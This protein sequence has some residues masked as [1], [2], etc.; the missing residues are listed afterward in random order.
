MELRCLTSPLPPLSTLRLRTHLNLFV[1]ALIGLM[2]VGCSK[3]AATPDV[4]A[5]LPLDPEAL[6]ARL[7]AAKPGDVISLP[8][9]TFTMRRGLNLS[10][11]G[12]TIRGAGKEATI[13][14][15]GTQSQGAEGLL[16]NASNFTIEGL[17][18]RNTRGDALK[19]NEG[20]N[21]V[22]RSVR[23]E[24]TGGP[25]PHNGA[26]GIYPVQCEGVLIEDSEAVGASD[27]GIY[28]GQSSRII[29]RNNRAEQ[30]VA[31]IEIENSTLADVHDNVVTNN[32]GGILVFDLP[33]IPVQGGHGTRVFKNRI[34]DNNTANFAPEGNIVGTVP[35]GT[36]VMINANDNIEVFDNDISGHQTA[37][38][39]II[40]YL[41]TKRPIN[42]PKY[43]PYPESIHVHHNRIGRGGWDPASDD[44]ARVRTK[45]S[46]GSLPAVLWDGIVNPA[47]L[48]NG[49]LP[50]AL[51]ICIHDNGTNTVAN[52]DA[53]NNFSNV[54]QDPSPFNCTLPALPPVK[55]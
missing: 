48:V 38:V 12:V 37:S 18:I 36:A 2:L 11:D 1:I 9:G 49:Q 26:Y 4:N 43:D 8:R 14:D 17:T 15:F 44:L 47:H 46:A 41:V 27:A 24:W 33:G 32:T 53:A 28:V 21:I 51:R 10:V 30:N 31:G 34:V 7:V 52:L 35:A 54:S 19:I 50:E 40:S 23:T 45:L 20:K 39:L 3:P 5:E 29:V 13:L 42:D 6:A 55:L 22:V 25:S 16:V